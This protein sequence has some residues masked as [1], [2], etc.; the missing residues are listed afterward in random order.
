MSLPPHTIAWF[1]AAALSILA[2]AKLMRRRQAA[3]VAVL[4][5]CVDNQ[6]EWSQ[7]K[8]KAAKL[9]RR[10]ARHKATEEAGESYDS[11]PP[12]SDRD[13]KYDLPENLPSMAGAPTGRGPELAVPSR[14][15]PAG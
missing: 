13:S 8:A 12:K 2:L 7:K 14:G 10:T 15:V 5:V 11:A 4:K 1:L 6:L 3:L 9:A